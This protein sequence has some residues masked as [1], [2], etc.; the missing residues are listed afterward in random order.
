MQTKGNVMKAKPT[1]KPVKPQ[2]TPLFL[3]VFSQEISE[4]W[5]HA[6]FKATQFR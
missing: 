1:V 3:G 2:A 6:S 4:D 5:C